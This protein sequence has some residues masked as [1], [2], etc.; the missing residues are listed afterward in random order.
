[1]AELL[2]ALADA[3][4]D[5]ANLQDTIVA[6]DRTIRDLTEQSPSRRT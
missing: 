1:L 4:T 5:L 3:K 2:S 6:K